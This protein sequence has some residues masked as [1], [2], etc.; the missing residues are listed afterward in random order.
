[1]SILSLNPYHHVIF[2]VSEI[3]KINWAE[4]H[5][6]SAS[7]LRKS[8]DG[9]KTFV[10]WEGETVP[11]CVEPLTTKSSYYTYEEMLAILRTSEWTVPLAP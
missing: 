7:E 4:V 3:D 5:E 11:V 10:K 6:V 1:M 8:L 2:S 9:T